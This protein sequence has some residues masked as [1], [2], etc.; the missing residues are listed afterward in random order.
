MSTEQQPLVTS[1]SKSGTIPQNYWLMFKIMFAV[2]IVILL[3]T[4]ILFIVF[5]IF[6]S[7]SYLLN[8]IKPSVLK[9]GQVITMFS[10][11][12]PFKYKVNT[13]EQYM[14]RLQQELATP[15]QMQVQQA[16]FAQQVA[17]YLAGTDAERSSDVNMAFT[18]QNDNVAMIMAN[19]GGY[20]CSR[21]VSNL[22]YMNMIERP[23]I[24]MGYSD[25]TAL[26]NAIYFTT[27]MV[28]FHGN[29]I[30]III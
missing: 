8:V 22:T 23:K 10:P 25:L 6:M 9:A 28:T 13:T 1:S 30:L 3:V 20:G 2:S 7:R 17:G 18:A 16:P 27:G 4:I 5:A 15:L 21:I 11:A 29:S 19:R 14:A 26:L 12:S 24:V